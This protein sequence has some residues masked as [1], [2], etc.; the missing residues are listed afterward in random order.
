MLA[1][2]IVDRH[3][4]QQLLWLMFW[5]ILGAVLRFANLDGKPP[6]ADEFRT[7]VLS[8]GNS[9]QSVPLDRTIDSS[10]LLAPLIPNPS[11]TLGDIIQRVSIEDRQPPI[12]FGLAFLW[13][14]LFATDGGLVS[15]W[16]AR[17]LPALI[18]VLTI[19]CAYIAS[20]LTFR[21]RQD[22][23][24]MA[25]SIANLT[26]AMLAVSP[27][28][29][30]I[31]QEARHYSLAIL[32]T[33][34]VINCL[35]IACRYLTSAQNLPIP[36]MTIWVSANI[37]GMGTHYLFGIALLAQAVVL[38]FVWWRQICQP[39]PPATCMMA[40]KRRLQPKWWQLIV[41]ILSTIAGMSVWL[42]LLIT[43]VDRTLPGWIDNAPHK[44]IEILNP[45]FQIVGASISMM[46]LLLVEVT[47]LPTLSIFSDNPID[48]NIPIVIGSAILMLIFFV[49]V[50]P[51][52]DRGI[53]MQLR[54]PQFQI[55]TMAIVTFTTSAIGLYL[56]LPWLTG[57]DITRGARYH[58]VY[59]PGIVMLVGLGLA[60][61]WYSKPSI[62]K[63][64][65]GTRA[66]KI[67]LLM[68][69]VSSAIVAGNYGYHKYYR[70]E[71]IVPM[72]QQ[73]APIPVLIATT[74]NSLIQVGEMMGLAW[75][76]QQADPMVGI[77]SPTERLRSLP[78][79]AVKEKPG[80]TTKFLLASQSQK[81]C[82]RDCAATKLLR[83]TVERFSGSIDLWLVNFYAPTSLPPTCDRDKKK[84]T[85]GV[86]GY[87]YQLYHCQPIRDNA[88]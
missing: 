87:K 82:E 44:S 58:F 17:A 11:V 73:S 71:Q 31:A 14:K 62:A 41:A 47:E 57:V 60:S 3:W 6:W 2:K 54:Q 84:F 83:Q 40:K 56:L 64:I 38:V 15:L 18:G 74:H 67:V 27:Y 43:T 70:T 25:R 81:F 28:G 69:L 59:F 66:V 50:T 75:E 61:C 29:V 85:K 88:S 16:G 10:E 53:G 52:L 45:F 32:W 5:I 4:R 42:W 36:L 79:A 72:I 1:A 35:A 78:V 39:P 49:W 24:K 23:S 76:L 30:F 80:V 22:D 9:F 26:A 7:L 13:M 77:I 68:G 51:M 34:V 65:S 19:P 33:I 8:L 86:Y 55:E 21:S 20:Y 37:L 12:Y 46:S 48:L 63:W